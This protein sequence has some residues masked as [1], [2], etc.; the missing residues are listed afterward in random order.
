[1]NALVPAAGM[2]FGHMERL[3][4]AIARSNLF[5]IMTKEQALVLMSIA[6]AE[7]RHPALAARD[8]DIIQGRPS[9]KAEAMLRDF[10]EAGGKVEWH[11][12]TDDKAEA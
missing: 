4:D 1:M 2:E 8:Y 10:L 6:Q 7:G 12:L 9:K 3:A 11:A 5:G